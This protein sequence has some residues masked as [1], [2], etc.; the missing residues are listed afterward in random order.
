MEMKRKYGPSLSDVLSYEKKAQAEYDSL[1]E[2]I[3]DNDTIRKTMKNSPPFSRKKR[4][5]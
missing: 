2:I 4:K 3:Y 1:K 5:Y